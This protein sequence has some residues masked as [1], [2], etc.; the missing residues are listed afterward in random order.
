MM[1]GVRER[2]GLSPV[3]LAGL[4]V[5]GVPRVIAHDLGLAGPLANGLL[6]FAPLLIWVVFVLVGKVP[7][8]F[9]ALLAVGLVYGVLLGLLHQVF[10]TAAF[11][12]DPPRLGGELAGALPAVLEDVVLRAIAFVSSLLTG[13]F[14]GVA[15][16]AVAWL[17]ARVIPVIRTR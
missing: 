14:V 13:A 7:A 4:A 5:L 17:L 12:G 3:A 8:P 9:L 10:W 6:V 15:A 1:C 16:G 2:L 11:A